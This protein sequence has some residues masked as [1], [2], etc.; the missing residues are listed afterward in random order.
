MKNKQFIDIQLFA[1]D[2]LTPEQMQEIVVNQKQQLEELTSKMSE[3]D[4]KL[5]EL[6]KSND[7]LK[8]VNNK[9]FTS[10]TSKEEDPQAKPKEVD[11][12]DNLDKIFED[13]NKKRIEKRTNK[14]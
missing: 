7:E 14:N 5:E 11:P 13:Y 4:A 8:R 2:G 3:K 6:N 12:E 1:E 9:L 10:I